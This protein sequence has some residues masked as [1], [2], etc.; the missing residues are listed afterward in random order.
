MAPG[1]SLHRRYLRPGQ[2]AVPCF[3]VLARHLVPG[4]GYKDLVGWAKNPDFDKTTLEL[5][6]V[7]IT[8]FNEANDRYEAETWPNGFYASPDQYPKP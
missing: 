8:P 2:R 4:L 5:D 7:R 1:R 6:W 3:T